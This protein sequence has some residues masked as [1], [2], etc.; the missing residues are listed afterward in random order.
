MQ[1]KF[2]IR[3]L[4]NKIKKLTY[5]FNI[6]ENLNMKNLIVAIL[7]LFT[8]NAYAANE[9]HDPVLKCKFFDKLIQNKGSY[10]ADWNGGCSNGLFQGSGDLK[11][12]GSEGLMYELK[13]TF[14]NGYASGESAFVFYDKKEGE[15]KY[16][17]MLLK[18]VIEG[19]GEIIYGGNKR[20]KATFK[21]FEPLKGTT[22]F[23]REKI[24]YEGEYK[25]HKYHGRGKFTQEFNDEEIVIFEGNFANDY[26]LKGKET[27]I[28]KSSGLQETWEGNFKNWQRDGPGII[29]FSNGDYISGS[30]RNGELEGRTEE[31]A[32]GVKIIGNRFKGILNGSVTFI[33]EG[34]EKLSR[35]AIDG[36]IDGLDMWDF[37]AKYREQIAAK[38]KN[39]ED[40]NFVNSLKA[41]D[42]FFRRY[43]DACMI[44]WQRE[45]VLKGVL[46]IGA[47]CKCAGEAIF[48]NDEISDPSKNRIASAMEFQ[49]KYGSQVRM[50]R[51]MLNDFEMLFYTAGL[52]CGKAGER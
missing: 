20:V 42:K 3:H 16:T 8:M 34:G 15:I 43:H 12:H 31:F 35:K 40:L 19:D 23:I 9:I 4:M 26:I 1:F 7:L 22:E 18:G 45:V 28:Y 38:K 44:T 29:R 10:R 47:I 6:H 24:F 49:A 14:I 41:K 27:I 52:M 33:F 48:S 5:V 21:N 36:K 11:V 25:G 37:I 17:G 39:L 46:N 50:P 30:H 32:G 13:T 2:N 51:G